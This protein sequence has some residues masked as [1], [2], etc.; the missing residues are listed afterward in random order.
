MGREGGAIPHAGSLAG[1][2]QAR[3]CK[4]FRFDVNKVQWLPGAHPH[5]LSS[6][7]TITQRD[8]THILNT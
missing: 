3:L 7:M 4:A 5:S 8:F 1:L 2:K 6:V